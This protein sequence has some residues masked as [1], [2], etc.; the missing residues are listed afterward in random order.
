[1]TLP[2]PQRALIAGHV[3]RCAELAPGF[4]WVAADNLHLTLRFVGQSSP[5]LVAALREALGEVPFGSFELTLGG[6]GTFGRGPRVRVCW[7]GVREGHEALT[8]LAQSIEAACRITGA[9]AQTRPY[10]AHL[11]LGRARNRDGAELPELPNP[12]AIPSW[13]VEEFCL[14]ES[15]P[16]RGNPVYTPLQTFTI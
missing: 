9:E 6:A 15:R 16:G 7:L 2:P 10:N 1:M 12:P 11:T 4:R 8:E 5:T 14:F 13:R 3:A